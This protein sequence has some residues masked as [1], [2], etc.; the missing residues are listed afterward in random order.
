MKK[1]L[2]FIFSLLLI[3]AM[4][5]NASFA[6][7]TVED[8]EKGTSYKETIEKE[9]PTLFSRILDFINTNKEEIISIGSTIG[10]VIS[11]IFIVYKNIKSVKKDN[12]G[13]KKELKTFGGSLLKMAEAHNLSAE[14]FN[15]LTT[16][17]QAL[18]QKEEE[19]DKMLA[20]L[21]SATSTLLDIQTTV[22]AN[23]KNLPS[24]IKDV[25]NVKYSK[26][27]KTLEN[28]TTLKAVFDA[29]KQEMDR[30]PEMIEVANTE[31]VE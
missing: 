22:Y 11:V 2:I 4:F 1:R 18:L 12:G 23:S 5:I 31:Q 7:E 26:C 15:R 27:L 20:I 10:A 29:V 24:G 16:S 6:T 28:N 21:V 8:E 25:I 17:Y 13:V 19:R 3:F 14:E 30:V 9:S